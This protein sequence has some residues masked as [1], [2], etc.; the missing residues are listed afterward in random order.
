MPRSLL[1]GATV[2]SLVVVGSCNLDEDPHRT[3]GPSHVEPRNILALC[4]IPLT[5]AVRCSATFFD[6]FG[7]TQDITQIAEWTSV[8][9][10][11]GA[12]T[13]PGVLTP[14]ARGEVTFIVKYNL[15]TTSST[16]TFFVDPNET[17]RYISFGP[18]NTVET[19]GTTPVANVTV[20]ITSGYRSGGSCVTNVIGSCSIQGIL[21]YEEFSGIATKPGYQPTPFTRTLSAPLGSGIPFPPIQLAR[22]QEP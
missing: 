17:A 19:D 7:R 11:I 9:P 6:G 18:F 14:I 5:T 20:S 8:P 1:V 4:Q 12:F 22:S 2:L 3:T 21:T 16:P 10:E 13:S 15:T